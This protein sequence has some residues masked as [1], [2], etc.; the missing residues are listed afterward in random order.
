MR[1]ITTIKLKKKHSHKRKKLHR[2]RKIMDSKREKEKLY[3]LINFLKE[4]F[5]GYT[6]YINKRINDQY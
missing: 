6:N 4:Q 1:M 5:D 2:K 3:I